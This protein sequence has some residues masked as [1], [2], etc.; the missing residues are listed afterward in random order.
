M[1]IRDRIKGISERKAREIALQ[2]EEKKEMREVMI[3]L[4][5][6]GISIAP[7]SYTHLL[8]HWSVRERYFAEQIQGRHLIPV[9]FRM[10]RF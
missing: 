10:E 7:V 9:I 1:C 3:Y 8:R 6:Y 5:K 2:V 4:Q